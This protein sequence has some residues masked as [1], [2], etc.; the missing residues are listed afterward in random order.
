MTQSD[1]E[2]SEALRE[3]Q[4]KGYAEADPTLDIEGI[5]SAHKLGILASLA[6]G[7]W[8]PFSS[9]YVEGISHIAQQDI[10]YAQEFNYTIKLLAIFKQNDNGVE[11]RVHPTLIPSRHLL[12]S[13]GGAFNA[14]CVNGDPVGEIVLYGAGAGQRPT[15]S[16]VLSDIIDI[17]LDISQGA[18][19]RVPIIPR[20]AEKKRIRKIEDISS[21]YYLRF[22]V[23]DQPGVLA[24]ITGI[25][26]KRQISIA[27][28]IQ[29]ERKKGSVVPV[30]IMTHRA[31][32]KNIQRALREISRFPYV[33]AKTTLIRVEDE[34]REK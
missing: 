15:S 3:A 19:A 23:I 11:A 14:V 1:V 21:K 10:K 6:S 29:T 22:S 9:V 25:L 7:S 34:E 30:V 12:A 33:R 16:A 17:A 2:F 20:K 18:Q 28:V 4:K 5:D 32:E 27:S 13:V 26:G 24:G 8:L 31:K